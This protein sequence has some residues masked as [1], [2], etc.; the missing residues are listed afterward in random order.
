MA[1]SKTINRNISEDLAAE[2]NDKAEES[3]KRKKLAKAKARAGRIKADKR[4][5]D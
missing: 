5:K 3:A 1:K 4:N 2:Q